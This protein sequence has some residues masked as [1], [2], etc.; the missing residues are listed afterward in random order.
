MK[1]EFSH[2]L[3][4]CHYFYVLCITI[5]FGHV[6]SYAK[7]FKI[8]H[9][10]GG[11]ATT[12]LTLVLLTQPNLVRFSK[13]LFLLKAYENKYLTKYWVRKCAPCAPSSAAPA[14]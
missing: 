1:F 2:I 6:N 7:I 12:Q 5:S 11:N 4:V 9:E 3:R 13:F 14:L 8:L 10:A